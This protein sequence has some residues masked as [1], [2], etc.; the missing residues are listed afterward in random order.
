M[1]GSCHLE[2]PSNVEIGVEYPI[3][4]VAVFFSCCCEMHF[5]A[6]S[7]TRKGWVI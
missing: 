7:R 1:R 2:K 4:F 3:I 5:G 6:S